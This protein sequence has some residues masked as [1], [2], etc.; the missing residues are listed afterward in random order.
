M[1]E[2]YRQRLL[3][4]GNPNFSGALSK[5]VFCR[6]CAQEILA[7]NKGRRYCSVRCYRASEEAEAA[8]GRRTGRRKDLNHDEI[9]AA[10]KKLGC[11]VLD[12]HEQGYGMP[13]LFVGVHGAWHPVEIKNAK[14][15]YG[16][17]GLNA[18]QRKVNKQMGGDFAIV[19]NIDDALGLVNSWRAVAPTGDRGHSPQIEQWSSPE[20]LLKAIGVV[21]D[22]GVKEAT[23]MRI[24]VDD[25]ELARVSEPHDI[26]DKPDA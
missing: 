7:Y 16:R 6:H 2:G 24:I 4:A 5:G 23:G 13:D 21:T 19:R 12:L 10:F 9:V 3:G 26:P 17:K 15:T 11:C 20:D 14:G 1:A 8:M 18:A 22:K 25:L